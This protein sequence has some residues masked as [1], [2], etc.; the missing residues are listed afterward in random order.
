MES[1]SSRASRRR[2]GR[3]WLHQTL[4]ALKNGQVDELILGAAVK[5][6][7]NAGIAEAHLKGE[8]CH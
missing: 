8:S 2:P 1:S 5:E 7:R 3:C 6:I 4:E